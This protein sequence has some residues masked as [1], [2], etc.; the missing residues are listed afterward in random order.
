MT[1]IKNHRHTQLMHFEYDALFTH[2]LHFN[3]ILT[4]RVYIKQLRKE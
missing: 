1:D 4:M 3:S 2:N